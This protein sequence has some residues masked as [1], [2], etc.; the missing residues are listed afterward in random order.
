MNNSDFSIDDLIRSLEI[1]AIQDG[2][3]FE[4][5]IES[6]EEQKYPR[7]EG[8]AWNPAISPGGTAYCKLVL[9]NRTSNQFNDLFVSAFWGPLNFD[10]NL[11]R[12]I[13]GRIREF[14][15]LTQ[16]PFYLRPDSAERIIFNNPLPSTFGPYVHVL[17]FY[18]WQR[19]FSSRGDLLNQGSLTFYRRDSE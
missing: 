13:A 10:D 9:V 7:I 18:V 6:V 14:P 16:G 12:A 8:A 2:Q 17:N 15:F 5:F 4:Q 1:S 3:E 19:K 11:G